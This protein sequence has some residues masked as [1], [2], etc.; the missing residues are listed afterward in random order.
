MTRMGRP[1]S[2]GG[3]PELS[4]VVP[5]LDEAGT[6]ET[7]IRRLIDAALPVPYEVMVIDDGST[8]GT[9]DAVC[10]A[11]E[12][13]P[14]VRMTVRR[15]P[16]PQGR[17]AC[18][19]DALAHAAGAWLLIQDGDLEYDPVDIPALLRAGLD[20]P[21]GAVYG[22]RFSAAA[23]PAKMALPNYVGNRLLT[24]LT[25]HLY[26]TRLTDTM[27]CYKLVS[28]AVLRRLALRARGFAFDSEL[29]AKLARAGLPITEVPI[30]YTARTRQQG[31]KIRAS[32]F[33]RCLAAL[34]RWRWGAPPGSSPR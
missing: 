16:A 32:D 26:G 17:G 12:A 15:H 21:G 33:W 2:Q 7:V 14:E 25:N 8:D 28:C 11:R 27:T 24:W 1:G 20:G 10:R 30:R 19:H 5:L 31:K 4:I 13:F 29:T 23:W 9:Y 34:L 6:A 22:S 18:I 3:P